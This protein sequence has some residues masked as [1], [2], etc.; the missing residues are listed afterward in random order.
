[1]RHLEKGCERANF[2]TSDVKMGTKV[3]ARISNGYQNDIKR[4]CL[5][6]RVSP[7]MKV[8]YKKG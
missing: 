5:L 3:A 1:M 7:Y 6:T 8:D 4:T 2:E